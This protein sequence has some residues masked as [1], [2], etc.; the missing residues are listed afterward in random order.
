MLDKEAY[1]DISD[2]GTGGKDSNLE[3]IVRQTITNDAGGD[4][5]SFPYRSSN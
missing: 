5:T 4:S 1:E 2:D 3:E